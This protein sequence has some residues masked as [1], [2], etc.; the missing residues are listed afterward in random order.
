MFLGYEWIKQF[1]MGPNQ[2]EVHI[3]F[4]VAGRKAFPLCF[5]SVEIE[6]RPLGVLGE[7]DLP[8]SCSPF[9]VCFMRWGLPELLGLSLN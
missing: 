7:R 5:Y 2:G 6:H 1:P 3:L 9:P 8:L 4:L